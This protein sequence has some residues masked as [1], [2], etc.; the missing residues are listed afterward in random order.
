MSV[1]ARTPDGEEVEGTTLTS[2][3]LLARLKNA[4]YL[5][6]RQCQFVELHAPDGYLFHEGSKPPYRASKSVDICPSEED[7]RNLTIETLVSLAD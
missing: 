7:P 5:L 3:N 4:A 1:K 2:D 6:P